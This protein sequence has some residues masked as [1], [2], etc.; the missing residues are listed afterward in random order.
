MELMRNPISRTLLLGLISAL[1]AAA[2]TCP[3]KVTLQDSFSTANPALNLYENANAKVVV[4][5]GKAEV[6][7]FKPSFA[8]PELYDNLR[9]TDANIC[10]TVAPVATDTAQKQDGGI[11]FWADSYTSYYTFE[12]S[13]EGKFSVSKM[14]AGKWT[15]LVVPTP[16]SAIVQGMGKANTLRVSTKGSTATLFINDQQVGTVNG[17]PPANGGLVGFVGDSSEPLTGT[18]SFDFT[19]FAVAVP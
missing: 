11:A 3:G 9:F 15:Y 17:T 14:D 7:V 19:D 12:I 2:A 16:N 1:P 10:A 18:V 6:T 4:Q 5:G 8:R 13:P